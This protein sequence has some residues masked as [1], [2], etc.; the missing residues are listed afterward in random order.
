MKKTP[1]V[2]AARRNLELSGAASAPQVNRNR[3]PMIDRDSA[4][5]MGQGMYWTGNPCKHGHIAF[6]YTNSKQCTVCISRRNRAKHRDTDFNNKMVAV[7]KLRDELAAK[8]L[9]EY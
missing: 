3:Y 1:A 5:V 6:R 9:Y 4:L 2:I 7:D 8:Q